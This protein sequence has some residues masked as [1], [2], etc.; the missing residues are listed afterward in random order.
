MDTFLSWSANTLLFQVIAINL[1]E[2]A[3][4]AFTLVGKLIPSSEPNLWRKM[5]LMFRK[6]VWCVSA[7]DVLGTTLDKESGTDYSVSLAS[8]PIL[9]GSLV[10]PNIGQSNK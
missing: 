4:F 2:D 8:A 5:F 1:N 10:L 9:S 7:L 6:P 3:S